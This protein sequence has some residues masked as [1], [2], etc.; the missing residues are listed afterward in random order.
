MKKYFILSFF[1]LI[2]FSCTTST[3]YVFDE[4]VPVEKSTWLLLDAVGNV[5]R[6]NDIPVNWVPSINKL[7]QIPAGETEL[8]WIIQRVTGTTVVGWKTQMETAVTRYNFL[9]GKQYY[10]KLQRIGDTFG[11]DIYVW[12][13]D[14]KISYT[15][16]ALEQ[17]FI[18]FEPFLYH[19]VTE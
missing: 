12:N 19:G 5:S 9:A 11:L 10:F 3:G 13:H 15:Q 18:G 7:F 2:I 16:K 8:E 1:V 6:Y 14:E 17:H 4:T